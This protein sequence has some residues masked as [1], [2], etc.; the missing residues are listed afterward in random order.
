MVLIM[1]IKINGD[2]LCNNIDNDIK[3][4]NNDRKFY[5][6]DFQDNV[7][8]DHHINHIDDHDKWFKSCQKYFN[9]LINITVRIPT[10]TG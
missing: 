2:N 6:R 8:N 7:N 9:I 10:N 3:N 4:N 1:N 5:N